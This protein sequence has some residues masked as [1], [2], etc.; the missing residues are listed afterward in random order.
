V[1]DAFIAPLRQYNVDGNINLIM[2]VD[3]ETT[4]EFG[5]RTDP[6]TGKLRFHKGLDIA[7]EYGTPVKAMAGG[8]VLDVGYQPNGYGNYVILGHEDKGWSGLT[9]RY[10]H[11]SEVSVKKDEIVSQGQAIGFMGNSGRVAPK[12][13]SERPKQGTHLHVELRIN[14]EPVNP[15]R[16]LDF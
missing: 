3:G 10:A 5:I 6:I 2:P 14:N 1:N 13:T 7:G 8:K 4:S 16:Y 12:P 11:L 15:R 9:S